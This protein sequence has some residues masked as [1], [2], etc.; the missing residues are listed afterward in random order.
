MVSLKRMKFWLSGVV[1]LVG[2]TGIA[3]AWAED[4][5]KIGVIAPF[6]T[7]PG[8][9]LLSAARMAAEDIN[10]AGGIGGKPLELVIANDEYKPDI[11]ANAYKKLALTDR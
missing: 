9:G 5:V 3:P 6:D 7:P 4:T 10:G 11:G 8:E 1:V 2:L